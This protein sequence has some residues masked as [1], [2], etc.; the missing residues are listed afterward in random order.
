VFMAVLNMR[1]DPDSNT[2]E[3]QLDRRGT[4]MQ[5]TLVLR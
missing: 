5:R 1:R 3:V 4:I 2:I